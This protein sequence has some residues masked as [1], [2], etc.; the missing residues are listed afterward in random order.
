MTPQPLCCLPA[1]AKACCHIWVAELGDW[2]SL[3]CSPSHVV[4][5]PKCWRTAGWVARSHRDHMMPLASCHAERTGI[6][7]GGQ[8]FDQVGQV[9]SSL[10]VAYMFT[11][12]EK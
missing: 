9:V 6:V 4:D 5:K 12:I 3:N 11:W 7:S 8:T 10:V 2:N 1:R